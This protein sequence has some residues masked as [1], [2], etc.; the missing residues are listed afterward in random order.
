MQ[1]GEHLAQLARDVD[2][3]A[4]VQRMAKFRHLF[5]EVAALDVFHHQVMA[6]FLIEAV[7]DR[8]D[9]GMAQLGQGI[10]FAGEIFVGFAALLRV[11]EVIDHLLER[12]RAIGQALVLREVNHSH[13]AAA[14]QLLDQVAV[15]EQRTAR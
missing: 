2:R 5:F 12:A 14:D 9:R 8:G 13:A 10:G 6:I 3:Q 4:L 1:V 15:L 7:A 11:D